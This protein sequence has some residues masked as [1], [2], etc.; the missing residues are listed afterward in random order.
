MKKRQKIKWRNLFKIIVLMICISVIV[1]DFYMMTIY[2]WMHKTTM[3]WTLYGGFTF[4][5]CGFIS[6]YL[7]DDLFGE[8]KND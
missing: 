2:S 1:H 3:G 4:M 5:L 8:E 7:F 6:E